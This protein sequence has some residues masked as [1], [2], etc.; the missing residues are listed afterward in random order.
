MK[1]G[2][3]YIIEFRDDTKSGALYFFSDNYYEQNIKKYLN[4]WYNE[5]EFKSLLFNKNTN[6]ENFPNRIEHHGK[7]EIRAKIIL[8]SLLKSR[9]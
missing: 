2:N 7:W 4:P 3:Y 8:E 6:K 1:F 5:N 9:P